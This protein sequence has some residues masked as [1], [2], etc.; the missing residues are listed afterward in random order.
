M[1]YFVSFSEEPKVPNEYLLKCPHCEQVFSGQQAINELKDHL[2][3]IHKE[4][5]PP[6][7]NF[8]CQKC[9]ASFTCKTNLAKHKLFHATNG[10]VS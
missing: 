4:S 1:M 8:V 6:E 9:N 5:S 7:A 3:T 2:A 10:Q